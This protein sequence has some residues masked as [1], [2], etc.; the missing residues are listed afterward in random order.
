MEDYLLVSA[1][2]GGKDYPSVL[3]SGLPPGWFQSGDTAISEAT[4]VSLIW[5]IFHLKK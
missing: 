5:Y 4:K 1:P 2:V 3:L